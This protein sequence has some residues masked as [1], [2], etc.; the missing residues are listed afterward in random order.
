VLWRQTFRDL[1]SEKAST[2]RALESRI[3]GVLSKVYQTAKPSQHENA[4]GK[5]MDN[6]Q[7]RSKEVN[8]TL[9]EMKQKMAALRNGPPPF[10][11]KQYIRESVV[12]NYNEPCPYDD[13]TIQQGLTNLMA[14]DV[15]HAGFEFTCRR[16][17]SVSWLPL[18]RAAQHGECPECGTRWAAKAEMP[19]RY[20]LNALAK[21]AVQRS[22]GA[23]PVL[24][25][26]W[27]LFRESKGSFLWYPNP[28]IYRPDY[29]GGLKPWHEMDIICVVDGKFTIGEAKEDISNFVESDFNDLG[30]IC[31][32]LQPDV[33]CLVFLEGDYATNSAFADRF[34]RL[35][36]RLVPG[37]ALEWRK[38]PSGW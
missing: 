9:D 20:R 35:K 3:K 14:R 32:A 38:I 21:R 29:E 7:G 1:A 25:A 6:I 37:T 31:E 27:T 19:W 12:L 8:L 17:G 34:T 10:P 18:G 28:E 36:A 26:I 22:G 2:D 5:I 16:C 13:E 24:L 15:I 33:A 11:P 23:I 4:L 30:D